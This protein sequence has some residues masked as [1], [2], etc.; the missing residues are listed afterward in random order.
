MFTRT[1][2]RSR[3]LQFTRT[4]RER[5]FRSRNFSNSGILDYIT[6][7]TVSEITLDIVQ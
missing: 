7:Q 2:F 1:I 5:S 6:T 4:V 3:R